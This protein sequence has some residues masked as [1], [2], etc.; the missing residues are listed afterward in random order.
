MISQRIGDYKNI[1]NTTR[2]L[3]EASFT[4]G[5]KLTKEVLAEKVPGSTPYQNPGRNIKS[6]QSNT[7]SKRSE[8]L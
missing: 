6:R 2:K 8:R 3:E 7:Q 4:G 1:M 5:A